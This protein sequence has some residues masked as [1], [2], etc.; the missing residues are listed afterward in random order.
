MNNPTPLLE[1]SHVPVMLN[2]VIKKKE[3]EK[4][5][6]PDA[7][8]TDDENKLNKIK[9]MIESQTTLDLIKESGPEKYKEVK[10]NKRDRK[11]IIREN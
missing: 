1:F 3:E 7:W 11:K 2:E 6:Y 10:E 9:E 8:T 5:K 4:T